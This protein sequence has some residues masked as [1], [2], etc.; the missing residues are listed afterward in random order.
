MS[1]AIWTKK[2]TRKTVFR[3]ATTPDDRICYFFANKIKPQ[4]MFTAPTKPRAPMNIGLETRN[5]AEVRMLYTERR[6]SKTPTMIIKLDKR[7]PIFADASKTSRA[8]STV[9]SLRSFSS[10]RLKAGAATT[11][12]FLFLFFFDN[13]RTTFVQV[14]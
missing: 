6:E 9:V 11:I 13:S 5:C 4:K 1:S 8:S 10:R 12:S 3:D 7:L 14:E 2:R